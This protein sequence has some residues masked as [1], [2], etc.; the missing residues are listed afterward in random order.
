VR[1]PRPVLAAGGAVALEG[2]A[3]LVVGLVALGTGGLATFGVWGFVVLLGA[4]V[5]A[6]GAA[7]LAGRRGARSP[8]VVTQLLALGIAFYAA[9]PS[10]RPGWGVPLAVLAV[11][12]L[13]GLLG[14]A[15]R[16]WADPDDE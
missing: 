9:V 1:A 11:A 16:A 10:G 6:V 14:A 4:G 2:L 5:T 12:V 8:A 3:L 7:V 13:A 15:G